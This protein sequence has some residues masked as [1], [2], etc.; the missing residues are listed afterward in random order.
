MVIL[1]G[2][3]SCGK[4]FTSDV[5]SKVF[6][7]R[8]YKDLGIRMLKENNLKTDVDDYSIGRDLA[9][10]QFAKKIDKPTLDM[11]VFDR[12]YISSCVYGIHYRNRY[13]KEFW[14]NHLKMVESIYKKSNT[15]VK[16]LFIELESEDFK[17]IVEM[18][19]KK[20]WLDTTDINDY[21]K[22]YLLYLDFLQYSSFPVIRMKAFQDEEYICKMFVEA[23]NA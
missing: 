16:I 18:K 19:R 3:R 2:I 21:I 1:E 4:T 13:D 22:Q 20:D 17:K 9:Y 12:Q 10:A 7:I 15:N 5:I 6:P 11:L 23:L 8:L 14:F